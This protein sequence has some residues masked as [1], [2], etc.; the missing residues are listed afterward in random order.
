MD[1]LLHLGYYATGQGEM[2]WGAFQGCHKEPGARD[3]PQLL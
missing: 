1:V 3:Y 2:G